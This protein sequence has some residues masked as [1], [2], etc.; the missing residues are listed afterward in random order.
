MS[1]LALKKNSQID[2]FHMIGVRLKPSDI[3]EG[4]YSMLMANDSC[5]V[6]EL[7]EMAGVTTSGYYKWLQRQMG[8]NEE[9]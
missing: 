5:T 3:F 7:C 6:V 9:T 4:I 8:K 2:G 1:L